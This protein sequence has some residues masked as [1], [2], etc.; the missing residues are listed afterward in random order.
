MANRPPL[1]LP[2]G[3]QKGSAMQLQHTLLRAKSVLAATGLSR[4]GHYAQVK[5][6][7]FPRPKKIDTRAVAWVSTDIE[8]WIA[9]RPVSDIAAPSRKVA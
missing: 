3:N 1:L 6:G 9:E 4:A 7:T 2:G 8:T 5:A